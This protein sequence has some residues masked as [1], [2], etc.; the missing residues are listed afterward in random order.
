VGR[1]V[2][3]ARIVEAS[4]SDPRVF[5]TLYDRHAPALAGYLIRRV[6]VTEGEGLLGELFRIAFESR[7][8]YQLDRT[9]ARPWLFGI[10]ANLV[11]KHFR[12]EMR[13]R[14]AV[15]RSVARRDVTPL[16]DE[17]VTDRMAAAD[18]WSRIAAVVEQLPGRD[19]EVLFLFAWEGLSYVEIGEALGI[20]TGTV[21]SRLNRVRTRI[22]E[23]GIADEQVPD[24]PPPRA[25]RGVVR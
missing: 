19:R 9:D 5:A 8:R 15:Q 23:L 1:T 4:L 14:D 20:P 16:L 2:G 10:A 24:V 17:Q 21:R 12:T 3:D 22:R 7:H 6:G 25:P 13:R 18:I 11:M